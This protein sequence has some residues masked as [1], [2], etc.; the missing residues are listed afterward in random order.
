MG[1]WEAPLQ[2]SPARSWVPGTRASAGLA[3]GTLVSEERGKGGQGWRGRMNKTGWC[4]RRTPGVP[5]EAPCSVGSREIQRGRKE[6]SGV[7]E[8]E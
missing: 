3:W 4:L 1:Q 8:E 6:A 5:S 7:G 2:P